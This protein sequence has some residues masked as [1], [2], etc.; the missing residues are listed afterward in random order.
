MRTILANLS[1][2]KV[3]FTLWYY[4]ADIPRSA[5]EYHR[6]NTYVRV[7]VRVRVRVQLSKNI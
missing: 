5:G 1:I 4:P 3:V 6:A 2:R 7:R